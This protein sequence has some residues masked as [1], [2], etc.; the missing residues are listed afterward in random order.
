MPETRYIREYQNGVLV[1]QIPYEVSDEELYQEQL[2]DEFN[3][4]HE[5]AILALKNWDSLTTA[6]KSNILKGLLKWCLWHRGYLH[7][8]TLD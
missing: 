6:Q 1:N 5:T 2:T 7:L 8:G 3:V 4:A